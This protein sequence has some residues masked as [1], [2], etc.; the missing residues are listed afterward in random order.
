[1][2]T[3]PEV[4]KA[5]QGMRPFL[6]PTVQGVIDMLEA[7]GDLTASDSLKKASQAFRNLFQSQNEIAVQNVRSSSMATTLP[8]LFFIGLPLLE[9]MT[10]VGSDKQK[11]FW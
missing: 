4:I 10:F 5:V 11:N 6:G 2:L 1:M 9:A 7:L 3:D 8:Y